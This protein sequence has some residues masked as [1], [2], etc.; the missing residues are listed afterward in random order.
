M[1]AYGL[2]VLSGIGVTLLVWM[3]LEAVRAPSEDELWPPEPL[4][5]RN[6]VAVGHS[7]PCMSCNLRGSCE[8]R[9]PGCRNYEGRNHR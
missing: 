6:R 1:I 9:V 2:G 3:V 4:E 7:F 5:E 8:G